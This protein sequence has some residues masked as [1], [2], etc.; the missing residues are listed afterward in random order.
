MVGE[1]PVGDLHL[2]AVEVLLVPGLAAADEDE[3]AAVRT[4]REPRPLRFRLMRSS[5]MLGW[6][7]PFT[8]STAG[9]PGAGPWARS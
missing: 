3:R 1:Q 2:I 8:E 6:C 9:R 4:E 5:F 7:E